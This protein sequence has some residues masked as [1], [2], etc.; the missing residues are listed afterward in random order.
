MTTLTFRE[1][2]ILAAETYSEELQRDIDNT[3]RKLDYIMAIKKALEEDSEDQKIKE[4]NEEH[5]FYEKVKMREEKNAKK[6]NS[7]QD[8]INRDYV[9]NE[10]SFKKLIGI[11]LKIVRRKEKKNRR[12]QILDKKSVTSYRNIHR[13]IM[14]NSRQVFRKILS[15][16][17]EEC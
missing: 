11:Y 7:V 5:K 14:R 9:D 13:P 1:E 6:E 17:N 16:D 3:K 8:T 4:I 15:F 2:L 12:D 10:I